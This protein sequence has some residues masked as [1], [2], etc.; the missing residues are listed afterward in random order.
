MKAE[1]DIEKAVDK[2]RAECGSTE[3]RWTGSIGIYPAVNRAEI[4]KLPVSRGIVTL[5]MLQYGVDSK[6]LTAV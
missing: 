5:Y 1:I 2:A 4:Y 6:I 3:M